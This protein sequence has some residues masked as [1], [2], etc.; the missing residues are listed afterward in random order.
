M[1]QHPM[2]GRENDKTKHSIPLKNLS[3]RFGFL[4]RIQVF[5]DISEKRK[6][7]LS[8]EK[9]KT[10]SSPPFK[11]FTICK[12]QIYTLVYIYI[13]PVQH[14]YAKVVHRY[15][16]KR[17]KYCMYIC[18]SIEY[19]L[20]NY[21]D[22]NWMTGSSYLVLQC[23][24]CKNIFFPMYSLAH[25]NKSYFLSLFRIQIYTLPIQNIQ[26]IF[27]NLVETKMFYIFSR[28]DSCELCACVAERTHVCGVKRKLA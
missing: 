19:V 22:V 23:Q 25:K 21:S 11:S 16:W 28:F 17:W 15:R 3:V 24:M 26:K 12:T 13:Q 5:F 2:D 8:G 4:L 20:V 14:T 27:T 1:L 7:F 9:K 18:R 6:T 10:L